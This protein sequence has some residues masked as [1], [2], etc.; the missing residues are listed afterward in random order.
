MVNEESHSVWWLAFGLVMTSATRFRIPVVPVGIGELMVFAWILANVRDVRVTSLT[1]GNRPTG[2]FAVYWAIAVVLLLA[3]SA[4]AASRN[5]AAA[6]GLRSWCAF[7]FAGFSVSVFCA[8][9]NL[10]ARARTLSIALVVCEIGVFAIIY[11]G[12]EVTRDLNGS[13]TNWYY[14]EIRYAG[15]AENPNQ[16]ALHLLGIPYLL[17]TW[18][19]AS[20]VFWHR[21]SLVPA[22]SVTYWMGLSTLSDALAVSWA[23]G[24]LGALLVGLLRTSNV[25]KQALILIGL[26]FTTVCSIWHQGSLYSPIVRM[27]SAEVVETRKIHP[28]FS[29]PRAAL[30]DSTKAIEDSRDEPRKRAV[31]FALWQHGLD[32][33]F[34]S[35]VLGLGPGAHS[36]LDKPFEAYEAHNSIIDWG[37]NSG[38][39]GVLLFAALIFCLF[40]MAWHDRNYAGAIGI[41]SLLMFAQF[42]YVFRQPIFWFYLVVFSYSGRAFCQGDDRAV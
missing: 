23:V 31:R 8:I 4:I 19:A 1:A 25:Q 16:A 11:I 10:Q 36:G 20:R 38:F 35:P 33:L 14:N 18:S 26:S 7:V 30:C 9:P 13:Y 21:L 37:T 12:A 22:V 15:F 28:I 5:L 29:R 40:K 2:L 17:A 6:D 32:A 24:A 39:A 41:L 34:T 3:G 42:H 27:F